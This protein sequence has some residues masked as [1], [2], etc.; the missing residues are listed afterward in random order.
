MPQ[1]LWGGRPVKVVRLTVGSRSLN[2]PAGFRPRISGDAGC[3]SQRRTRPDWQGPH[4]TRGRSRS[5]TQPSPA[6]SDP[7]VRSPS[8]S[9]L[10]GD[11]TTL[12]VLTAGRKQRDWLWAHAEH[13]CPAHCHG[14]VV[15]EEGNGGRLATTLDRRVVGGMLTPSDSVRADALPTMADRQWVRSYDV[16]ASSNRIS[17]RP[18]HQPSE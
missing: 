10:V 8:S 4:P 3:P 9:L 16:G 5:R 2:Q 14:D 6:S 15:V 7:R 18:R 13:D 12:D 1:Q 11:R 17:D